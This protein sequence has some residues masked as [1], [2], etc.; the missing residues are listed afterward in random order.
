MRIDRVEI[1]PISVGLSR[2]FRVTGTSI[3]ER[4][5][6]LTRIFTDDGIVGECYN[7][8]K[9]GSSQR[10]IVSIV[11]E[12]LTPLLIGQN[13]LSVQRLWEQM[14]AVTRNVRLDRWHALAAISTVD[15]ALWDVVGKVAT[16]PLHQI[17]GSYAHELPI[18]GIGGYYPSTLESLAAEALRFRE[19]GF[20]GCK[21]KVGD[22][23]PEDDAVRIRAMR[24]ACGEDFIL[25]A[26]ANGGWSVREALKFARLVG[27]LN[28]RW[29]EEPVHWEDATLGMRQ[30]RNW[31]AVP[32]SAGQSQ[33]GAAEMRDLMQNDAID[34]CNLDASISGGPTEWRRV[35]GLAEAFSVDMAH[36]EEPHL[37]VQ[38]L[39]S[40]PR[41]TFVECFSPER[42]PLYW[43]M[44][45]NRPRASR[46]VV[47]VPMMPGWGLEYDWD[48]ISA[49]RV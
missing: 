46:G 8:D 48:W 18:V 35:A 39:A 41:A 4:A 38:L 20:V 7:G 21:M 24:D 28:L 12:L 40:A 30:V 29:F 16:L 42:D 43:N 17:W 47:T 31:A 45:T 1:I 11:E 49:H 22:E 13:P 27:D 5:T 25:M 19:L 33:Q 10:A 34:V 44:V 32:V 23:S 14:I 3:K 2:E 37:A 36:H 15:C 6:V 9:P 26:D